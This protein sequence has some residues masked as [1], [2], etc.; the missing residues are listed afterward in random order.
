MLMD[1]QGIQRKGEKKYI[2]CF[3]YKTLNSL[4]RFQSIVLN[5]FDNINSFLRFACCDGHAES[6]KW[7]LE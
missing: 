6:E 7:K 5:P 1:K 3:C 4:G 2:L